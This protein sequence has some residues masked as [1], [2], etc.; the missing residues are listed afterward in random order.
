MKKTQTTQEVQEPSIEKEVQ[1]VH[2]NAPDQ[3]A[4]TPAREYL[5]KKYTPEE[6]EQGHCA[7]TAQKTLE[8]IGIEKLQEIQRQAG[9][10]AKMTDHTPDNPEY[11]PKT[12]P[13]NPLFD[14]EEWKKAAINE[15][16]ETLN[17]TVKSAQE[18]TTTAVKHAAAMTPI[19]TNAINAIL[20][21]AQTDT[22]AIKKEI[23]SL[24]EII[25]ENQELF[26]NIA[27]D[28]EELEQ[29]KPYI[30]AELEEFKKED[31]QYSWLTL[32][33]IINSDDDNS[34]LGTISTQII[35]KA[36]RKKETED[37]GTKSVAENV[38]NTQQAAEL[39]NIQYKKT[40]D[41]M[42]STDY[43][44]RI[45]FSPDSFPPDET[46]QLS[47]AIKR[48]KKNKEITTIPVFY[49]YTFDESI[50]KDNGLEKNFDAFDLFVITV[51]DN[52]YAAG[53]NT[54]SVTKIYHEMGGKGNPGSKH[55]EPIYNTLAKAQ[56]TIIT[57]D[58]NE[59]QKA[60]GKP[61]HKQYRG[62]VM[63]ISIIAEKYK[64]SGKISDIQVKIYDYSPFM[65][66]AKPLGHI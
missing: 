43:L 37:S 50:M 39:L 61:T 52:L 58:D 48:S 20:Q 62:P 18:G 6:M 65:R 40:T 24:L 45:F 5:R 38:P 56:A 8:E 7:A 2:K 46:H 47:Y 55:L 31:S 41:F 4:Q 57:I 63:Q 19:I 26:D 15:L 54:V 49:S 36:K 14:I 34:P 12:D 9:E 21:T 25:R 27:Q 28:L 10:A 44:T 22:D 59:V 42:M 53:N 29:L 64:A 13:N 17:Y 1:E 11:N 23:F 3:A 30:E 32:D 16:L 66:I 33:D 35:E 51:L 60:W